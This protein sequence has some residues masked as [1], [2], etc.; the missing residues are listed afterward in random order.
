[1][2]PGIDAGWSR[3]G[4]FSVGFSLTPEGEVFGAR[5]ESSTIP[6]ISAQACVL[7]ALRSTRFPP[8]RGEDAGKQESWGLKFSE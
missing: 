8:P 3:G 6:E 7:E 5:L 4:E 1:M 2:V